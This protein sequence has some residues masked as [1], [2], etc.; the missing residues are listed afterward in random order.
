M[1]SPPPTLASRNSSSLDG[2]ASHLMETLEPRS[3]RGPL[4]HSEVAVSSAFNSTRPPLAPSSA[5]RKRD[6][7]DDRSMAAATGPSTPS[8]NASIQSEDEKRQATNL[9]QQFGQELSNSSL[10]GIQASHSVSMRS[11][12][13]N[14]MS[15][16]TALSLFAANCFHHY[17]NSLSIPS[18]SPSATQ[19]LGSQGEGNILTLDI[20]T[21]PQQTSAHG[22]G[23]LL[24]RRR[25]LAMGCTSDALDTSTT[26]EDTDEDPHEYRRRES[27]QE[28]LVNSQECLDVGTNHHYLYGE[29]D[30][31]V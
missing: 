15:I 2:F 27:S 24:E 22:H 4:S 28:V 5:K 10:T 26:S 6:G 17:H 18:A 30:L 3:S 23:D 21:T 8:Q 19:S 25:S 12:S 11:A 31:S 16:A 9:D 20:Q 13:P 1:S 29:E 14:S 7:A